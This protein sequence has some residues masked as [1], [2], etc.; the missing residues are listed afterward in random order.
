MVTVQLNGDFAQDSQRPLV[1]VSFPG[2]RYI[3][4]AD[5]DIIQFSDEYARFKASMN[6]ENETKKPEPVRVQVNLSNQSFQ[7]F[8]Q[9][10]RGQ[11]VTL[12]DRNFDELHLLAN[13][14]DIPGLRDACMAFETDYFNEN[15]DPLE[16]GKRV[17]GTIKHRIELQIPTGDL[18][19]LLCKKLGTFAHE[20]SSLLPLVREIG[21]SIFARVFAM[22]DGELLRKHSNG[23]HE[24]L[25][26]LGISFPD[27]IPLLPLDGIENWPAKQRSGLWQFESTRTY[28]FKGLELDLLR[29]RYLII[30]L[31][32]VS[33]LGVCVLLW[34]NYRYE[35]LLDGSLQNE[36]ISSLEKSLREQSEEMKTSLSQTAG[37]VVSEVDTS[38]GEALGHTMN[39]VQQLK[40]MINDVQQLK[41]MI[42][43]VLEE[44]KVTHQL[45]NEV[46]TGINLRIDNL[47]SLLKEHQV[48]MRSMIDQTVTE[49]R[50]T[51]VGQRICIV[52]VS[53]FCV[54]RLI[55]LCVR[56]R[57]SLYR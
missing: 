33:V 4:V 21:V 13:E 23:L 1:T 54:Y 2:N 19:E 49:T 7:D 28:L 8:Q 37:R 47:E 26:V 16:L 55:C 34:N 24:F 38:L 14:L 35:K 48:N 27:W 56:R 6:Y 45:I 20:I 18:E 50:K 29:M 43:D 5:R 22:H 41:D 36:S 9:L 44:R 42:N 52:F 39:D 57:R 11:A 17:L 46:V 10:C 30:T 51:F 40:D 32:A 31:A 25:C 3:Q 12:S 53:L 15:Q